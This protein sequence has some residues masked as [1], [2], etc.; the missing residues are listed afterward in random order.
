MVQ[1]E[2]IKRVKTL[3]LE[4]SNISAVLMY[5]SFMKGE[6]DQFSD[7]EFYT[8]YFLSGYIP[9]LIITIGKVRQ[10]N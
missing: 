5:G 6:G 7:I 10:R 2:M 4:N 3:A 9:G 1:L 8:F